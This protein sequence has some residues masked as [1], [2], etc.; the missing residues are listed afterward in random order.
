MANSR[1]AK[2]RIRQNL[3]RKLA[4]K[5]YRSMV[6]TTVKTFEALVKEADQAT[7]AE[8]FVKVQK[9]LDT[10]ARKGHMHKNTVARKLSRLSKRL[11]AKA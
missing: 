3:T 6:R 9:V 7:A 10:A 11:A 8:K 5:S 1:S 4:N 2:K